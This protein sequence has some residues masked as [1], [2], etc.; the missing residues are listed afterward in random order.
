ML[1]EEFTNAD[2]SQ[3]EAM[4]QYMYTGSLE[5]AQQYAEEVC[6]IADKYAVLQL[7]VRETR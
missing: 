5:A 4:I 7:K 6:A 3:V 2:F 1:H